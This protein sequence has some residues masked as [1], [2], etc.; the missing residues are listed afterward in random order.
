MSF[1]QVQPLQ[2]QFEH[3]W[4]HSRT[5]E[6]WRQWWKWKF[7]FLSNSA[8]I[9]VRCQQKLI[10]LKRLW[11][12]RIQWARQSFSHGLNTSGRRNINFKRGGQ[13]SEEENVSDVGDVD[14]ED[15]EGRQSST[16]HFLTVIFNIRYRTKFIQINTRLFKKEWCSDI[17]RQ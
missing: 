4:T 11:R 7:A 17:Y 1:Y 3:S 10:K 13:R 2:Q 8:S 6:T 9:N 16:V 15:V 5:R 12:V 14:Y